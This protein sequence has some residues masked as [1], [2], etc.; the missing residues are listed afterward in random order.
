MVE[1]R[2]ARRCGIAVFWLLFGTVMLAQAPAGGPPTEHAMTDAADPAAQRA[3]QMAALRAEAA[4][5]QAAVQQV[6]PSKKN[7]LARSV[8]RS[9]GCADCHGEAEMADGMGERRTG[10]T[11]AI[12]ERRPD[13]VTTCAKCHAPAMAAF[14]PSAHASG[15]GRGAPNAAT[16]VACHGSHSVRA[17]RDPESPVSTL[18]VSETC[19]RCHDPANG[20]AQQRRQ[21]NVVTDY[22]QSFHGL[23]AALGDRRVATCVNCHG[24]HEIRPSRDPLSSV[25]AAKLHQTCASCHT[26]TTPRFAA[27]GVHHNPDR[28]GHQVVDIVRFLYLMAII[29][30]I[31]AMLLHNGLDFRGRL[32]ERRLQRSATPRGSVRGATHLRFSVTERVQHWTLAA[33]FGLLALTG[34]ALV[35]GWRIP[36]VD[37]QQGAILRGVLHRTAAV[38]FITLSVFHVGYVLLTRRGRE[39]LHATFPHAH[40]AHDWFC[41]F[42]ACFRLGPPSGADWRDL[43]QTVKYNLGIVPARPAMGRFTYAEKMEY[44]AMLWGSGV[45]IVTGLLLWVKMPFLNRFQYWVF[46][47]VT[48]VHFYE[49]LLAT[50]SVLAW[51]FYYTIYNPHVFPMATTMVTGRISHEDMERDHALELRPPE[52][53]AAHDVPDAADPPPP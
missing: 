23:A 12:G 4:R 7:A 36:F 53:H 33:S 14:L 6:S 51:H 16:C 34:F 46:D 22:R 47:L 30:V 39:N 10:S 28:S 2:N 48:T 27:G 31:G 42:A 43:V 29:L 13:P 35:Y 19:A 11:R 24:R 37:A 3:E 40:S 9:L 21:A 52:E 8:H 17:V 18:R 15:S 49:A 1:G 26:G 32:R 41:R 44:V 45:M 5:L 20:T 50:L 25:S 38:V